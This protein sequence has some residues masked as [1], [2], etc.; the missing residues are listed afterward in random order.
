MSLIGVRFTLRHTERLRITHARDA[1]RAYLREPRR[2]AYSTYIAAALEAETGIDL[3][4]DDGGHVP[5]NAAEIHALQA[6]TSRPRPS[7]FGVV[8]LE[9]D[10]CARWPRDNPSRL[11]LDVAIWTIGSAASDRLSSKVDWIARFATA[12]C[13][14]SPG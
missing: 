14:G 1:H 12:R 13:S 6:K 3:K 8:V 4:G 11:V 2:E 7:D 10:V 5:L 9:H